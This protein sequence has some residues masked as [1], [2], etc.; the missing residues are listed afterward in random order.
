MAGEVLELGPGVEN[1]KVGQ[2]VFGMSLFGGFAEETVMDSSVSMSYVSVITF[3]IN[4]VHPY[5]VHVIDTCMSDN[6]LFNLHILE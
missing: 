1:V 2:R 4:S 5:I 6:I 3:V